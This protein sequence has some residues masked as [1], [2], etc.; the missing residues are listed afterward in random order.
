MATLTLQQML[1]EANAALHRLQ[2]GQM[3]VEVEIAG[4]LR[5]TFAPAQIDKLQAY[6]QQLT[7][8]VNGVTKLRG[9]I[10]FVF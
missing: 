3:A 5:T 10:G 2:I 9:S 4:G 8:Q 7:D 1:D 6:I